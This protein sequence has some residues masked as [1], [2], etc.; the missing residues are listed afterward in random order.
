MGSGCAAK[1]KELMAL[2]W[3]IA[4]LVCGIELLREIDWTTRSAEQ[5]HGSVAVLH[6]FHP[7]VQ[8]ET[9]SL[10]HQGRALFREAQETLQIAKMEA[11]CER[12]ATKGWAGRTGRHA[13]F[14]AVMQA[15]SAQLPR[16]SRLSPHKGRH[17]ENALVLVR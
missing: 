11:Q 5:A 14:A 15:A 9:R 17:T 3:N 4:N 2:G 1:I 10:L 13:F 12:L 16:G 6:K 7:E 8:Q